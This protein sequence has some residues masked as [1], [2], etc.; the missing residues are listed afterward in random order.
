MRLR[1]KQATIFA[2]HRHRRQN[3]DV[4]RGMR[5]EPEQM[6]EQQRIA[7]AGGIEDAQIES[8]FEHHQQ[9]RNRQHRRSQQLD[10]A[11][12]VVRPDEQRQA[13]PGH[14]RRAHAVNGDHEIQAGKDGRE[15]GDEDC[16]SRLN[17][18]GIAESRAE[19][20]V[21]GPARVHAAG[22][23]AVHIDHAGN[24]VEIPAQQIDAR[25]RQVFG[26]DHHGDEK[27][28]QH[29]G[30]GRNQEEEDHH[31]AVHGE[32]LVVGVGLHQI[33]RRGQQFQPDQQREESADK[34][35]ERN[36]NQIQQRDALVVRGQQPR[37]NAVFL[38]QIMF[39]FGGN[40]CGRHCYSLGF[41]DFVPAGAEAG[42]RLPLPTEPGSTT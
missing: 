2:L 29:G 1:E 14:A 33:A 39:A 12:G 11:G 3:H 18:P 4:N 41:C 7:A 30:D 24:D 13:R 34:E 9:Q 6:L 8:A 26:A 23:D 10:D 35:E 17:H 25:K 5:V 16:D 31:L 42:S 22:E 20:R 28:P 40:C 37:A 21:E 38:I 19:R 15:S 36:R 27:I 32:E